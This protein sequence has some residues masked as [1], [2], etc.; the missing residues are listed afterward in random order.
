MA[1]AAVDT[2]ALPPPPTAESFPLPPI[3]RQPSS[4][5]P[6]LITQGAEGR[7]YKTTYLLPSVPC[8]LKY[9]PAKPW[10]HPTLDARLTKHRIL[11]EARILTKCRRDG[12]RVP[13]VY[14][15][16]EAQGWLML[17][18]IPGPPVRAAVNARLLGLSR[19]TGHHDDDDGDDEEARIARDG[20]LRSLMR[21][22]GAA[23]GALHKIG[24]VHGDLTTSNMMLDP[25]GSASASGGSGDSDG[26]AELEGEV[27]IIDLG[28][29]S[30]AVQE[31]D[32]A[33]D[34]YVLERAFGSTH[35]RAECV[36]PELLDA[37]RE[38]H[39]Q[40]PAV[41]K[42]LEEVRMRGR[43]RSMLG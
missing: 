24:I 40:A 42:K 9:R 39:K 8:A 32:R 35:P 21:R 20:P 16:D 23:V 5:A 30:G 10:R 12:V 1:A 33:V 15:L 18:W 43:K 36:F 29:A 4:T 38:S 26:S 3:L 11:S 7:L 22:I 17:E 34:L 6:E 14:G 41:L 27:V 37:Y 2:P 19:G 31:E 25:T 28:L 13:A